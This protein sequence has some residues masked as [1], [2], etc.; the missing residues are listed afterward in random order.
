MNQGVIDIPFWRMSFVYI[1]AL[2]PFSIMLLNGVKLLKDGIISIVRM[3]MQLGLVGLYLGV[4]FELNNFWLNV[5]WILVM[6][7]VCSSNIINSNKLKYK[8]FIAPILSAVSISVIINMLYFNYFIVHVDQLFNAK[9]LI[10]ISGM[11]LGN[12]LKGSIVVTNSFFDYFVNNEKE[13]LFTLSL[14]ACKQETVKPVIRKSLTNALKLNVSGMATIGLVALPGMMTGQI[15]GGSSPMI[16]VKYQCA[17]MVT[18][19][20]T[21]SLAI[22]LIL[23]FYSKVSFNEY[24]VLR[25]D[26]LRK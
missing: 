14:T 8:Y 17:I 9:Y 3:S 25:D 19:F 13:Y 23:L 20:S 21:V 16:A 11:L 12:T 10:P 26:I 15:L 5:L 6:A 1:L 4:I 7:V 22:Y 24:G 18:I 2:I